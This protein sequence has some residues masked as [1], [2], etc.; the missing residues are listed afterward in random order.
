[1]DLLASGGI[2][3]RIKLWDVATGE[4]KATF[5]DSHTQWVSCL[6]VVPST[7]F[8][9]SS[10][11]DKSVKVW[12]VTTGKCVQTLTGHGGTVYGIAVDPSTQILSVSR[13]NTLK[14]WSDLKAASARRRYCVLACLSSLTAKLYA[15]EEDAAG[16]VKKP[17]R[18]EVSDEDEAVKG[19]GGE[20]GAGRLQ[21][22]L[23]FDS[24]TSA[25]VW[26]YILEFV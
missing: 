4:C 7:T 5:T 19:G 10:S 23:A 22:V 17:S 6:A 12:D 18:D 11:W 9:A 16:A 21:G 13:D 14:V 20:V 3:G 1:L 8:F 26:R 15:G 24:I 2:D 25:D